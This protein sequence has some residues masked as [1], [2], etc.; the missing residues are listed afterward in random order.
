M[1]GWYAFPGGA[2]DKADAAVEP[3]GRMV[4]R[5]LI[6]DP[7]RVTLQPE[8]RVE[9][10][11]LIPGIAAAALRELEEEIGVRVAA[12]EAL[13]ASR[14]VFAGRW[15]TPPLSPMRFDN[16]FF[17]LR[18]L[19][20]DAEPRV[21]PGELALGEWIEP[22]EALARWRSGEVLVAPPVLHLLEVLAESGIEG[23]LAR[24]LDTSETHF[25]S[26]RKIE[27]RPGYLVFP[28]ATPTLP[29]ASHTNAILAG[30]GDTVLIDPGSPSLD[31]QTRLEQALRSA[32]EQ[33]GLQL[34]AVVLTH[35][36][37]DHVGGAEAIR[38]AFGVPVWAHEETA[39]RLQERGFAVDRTIEDGM[40]IHLRGS[41]DMT[42][43]VVHTPGHAR[44]HLALFDEEQR[45]LIAGDLVSGLS[46]IVIDPPEGDL[47]DYLTSLE[48]AAGLGASLLIPAHGSA[49][50]RPARQLRQAIEH[51]LWRERKILD[52]W[53]RGLRSPDELL[54]EV[55]NDTPEFVRPLAARQLE[56]HLERLG[57]RDLLE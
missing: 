9:G 48:R 21:E 43:R 50:L 28:L 46:T 22:A 19:E 52:A 6:D 7:S 3:S 17:L 38:R 29:P 35:H 4:G 13:D 42:L 5:P 11:D 25:G 36:H 31:E 2:L 16:R 20:G 18:W 1:G 40:A 30:F 41:R 24:L 32:C 55:Y 33:R 12:G 23:G 27:F 45:V 15:L 8:G 47:D 26:F 51:R 56:A 44:G 53:N 10:P 54:E 57:R 34:T 39:R 37:P 14:L 49:L